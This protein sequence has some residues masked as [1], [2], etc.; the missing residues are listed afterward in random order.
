MEKLK[1]LAEWIGEVIMNSKEDCCWLSVGDEGSGK[2]TLGL[3]LCSCVDP[4]FSINNVVFTLEDFAE[5]LRMLPPGSAILCDEAGDLLLSRE[6]MA[7]HRIATIKDL[8]KARGLQK[9]LFFNITYLPLMEKYVRSFRARVLSRTKTETDVKNARVLRG[10]VLLY[11]KQSIP[12]INIDQLGNIKW[13]RPDMVDSFP[14]LTGTKL[15]QQYEAKKME[16]LASTKKAK[17]ATH[18]V[19]DMVKQYP[20]IRKPGLVKLIR[21][22]YGWS[23]PT[24]YKKID[25]EEDLGYIKINPDKVVEIN[26]NLG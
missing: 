15:W 23:A 20:K 8:M 24:A 14:D 12:K 26:T 5:K 9:F 17:K 21:K 11:H 2:S 13:V 10:L 19:Y 6:S 18:P 16:Y 7:Q 25:F 4:N 3:W 22:E 1:N